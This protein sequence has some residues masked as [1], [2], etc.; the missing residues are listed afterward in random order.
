M[1]KVYGTRTPNIN[2][3]HMEKLYALMEN[4]SKVMEPGNTPP[5]DIFPFLKYV[6]QHLLGNWRSRGQNVGDEMNELYSDWLNKVKNRRDTSGAKDCFLDRVLD[7]ID[8]GKLEM[9]EHAIYFLCGTLME[10]GSDTTSSI[11]IAFIHALTKWPEV[12]KKA[13]KQ[14]DESV[15]EDRSPTWQDYGSL[16]YV[17]ACVKE[18]MRWRPVVPL[19]FPHV[20]SENDTV[21]GMFLPKGSQ[22]FLNAFGMQ[23]D[24]ERFENP[25]IFD[26]DHYAGV[27][28]LASE[29]ANGD[30]EKRD[31]YGYGTGRRICP[32]MHVAERNMFLAM[33][34]ILWALHIEPGA[35]STGKVAD[36][37]VSNEKAYSA[38]F[39]VCAEPFPCK[40][41]VR[42]EARLE[43]LRRE[44]DA[45]KSQIFC[46]FEQP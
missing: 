15:G 21:D 10:G 1:G 31:H 3:V 13:Q 42:S 18:S 35:D 39:L 45:A 6:P 5:V 9:G 8:A 27:T 25:D 7:Q 17:A 28:E 34:K 41:S 20:L 23:H 44:L 46:Q 30:W 32:G 16:P 29:L 26:P 2:T 36:P 38:G 22:I 12:Q 37:D 40:I 33:V 19:G 4:W 11:I 14:V 43:T 24:S